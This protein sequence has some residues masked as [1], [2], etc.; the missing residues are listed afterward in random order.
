MA[1]RAQAWEAGV[2]PA[3]CAN[4]THVTVADGDGNVVA[5][6]Q[7][8]NNLFGSR[9]IV[10]GTGIIPNNYMYLF[11]PHP[12]HAL[13]IAPGKRVTSVD[14]AADRAARRQAALRA[15]PA[16][17]PAHLRLGAAGADQPDRPRHDAAGG[18]RGAAHLDPGPGASRS[19][20]ASPR[21]VRAALAARGHDIVPRAHMSPA[22]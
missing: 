5:A 12:G 9:I 18:G 11:D 7:T 22:A 8:I 15:R 1:K 10:P 14:V 13:S 16:R 19:R 21:T 2:G 4:T 6:T 17:R 20:P 3:N